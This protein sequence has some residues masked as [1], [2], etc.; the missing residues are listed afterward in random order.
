VRPG[1]LRRFLILLLLLLVVLAAV[2]IA[3]LPPGAAVSPRTE[4]KPGWPV[5][6]GAYHIHS[7]RSD[8]TGTI[9][10]IAAAAARAGLQ[11]VILTD[12]GDGTRAPEPPSYRSSVLGRCRDSGIARLRQASAL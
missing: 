7:A 8:G 2:T 10:E 5:A 9:D 4:W 6:K 11:F 1:L 3:V 12:H